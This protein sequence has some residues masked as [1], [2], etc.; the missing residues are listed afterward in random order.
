M[1]LE[2]ILRLETEMQQVRNGSIVKHI[3]EAIHWKTTT[4]KLI[5]GTDYTV[6]GNLT[7]LDLNKWTSNKAKYVILRG[8]H[9]S[10]CSAS[11]R[12]FIVKNKGTL[13]GPA[14]NLYAQVNGMKQQSEATMCPLDENQK[15]QYYITDASDTEIHILGYIE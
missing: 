4:K 15:V 10:N 6:D 5:G 9:T 7:E 8:Y 14:V 2:R 1:L 11:D 13:D 3:S 12:I